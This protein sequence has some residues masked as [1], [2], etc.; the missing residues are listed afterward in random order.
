[1]SERRI[2]RSEQHN[3]TQLLFNSM[4]CFVDP[5]FKDLR[6]NNNINIKDG[7]CEYNS[8]LQKYIIDVYYPHE[9]EIYRNKYAITGDCGLYISINTTFGTECGESMFYLV[10]SHYIKTDTITDVIENSRE[11]LTIGSYASVLPYQDQTKI[12]IIVYF[13]HTKSGCYVSHVETQV[14]IPCGQKWYNA[15]KNKVNQMSQKINNICLD[16]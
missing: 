9:C 13:E 12:D 10:R 14:G 6:N 2:L 16:Y 5:T 15:Y 7:I 8:E 11:S 1:M 3:I 4:V